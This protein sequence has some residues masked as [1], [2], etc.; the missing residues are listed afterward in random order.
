MLSRGRL[1]AQ[2]AQCSF[3]RPPPPHTHTHTSLSLYTYCILFFC[4]FTCL[5]LLF[6][7]PFRFI[8]DNSLIF[9]LLSPSPS[10]SFS[11][12]FCSF[13]SFLSFCIFLFSLDSSICLSS[14][15]PPLSISL[16]FSYPYPPSF[17]SL[18]HSTWLWLSVCLSLSI[19]TPPPPPSLSSTHLSFLALYVQTSFSCPS[20]NKVAYT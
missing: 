4:S 6:P 12:C 20:G 17:V 5:S 18:C 16:P 13:P 14:F 7:S 2:V 8:Y 1:A 9:S 19:S 15:L 10:L 3:Q 11:A